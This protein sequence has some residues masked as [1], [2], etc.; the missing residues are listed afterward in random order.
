MVAWRLI[1]QGDSRDSP[2]NAV[3]IFFSEVFPL[4]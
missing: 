3:R 4:L 2:P 1:Q